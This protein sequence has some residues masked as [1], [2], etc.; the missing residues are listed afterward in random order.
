[1][2]SSCALAF[3]QAALGLS[4]AD[5]LYSRRSMAEPRFD[6]HPAV[7]ELMR[8]P[9]YPLPRT[10]H[11][12]SSSSTSPASFS[13]SS[14]SLSSSS[15]P[16]FSSGAAQELAWAALAARLEAGGRH[17]VLRHA[18]GL[19]ELGARVHDRQVGPG[20]LAGWGVAKPGVLTAWGL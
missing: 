18:I 4:R 9:G 11:P 5:S 1:M 7:V 17:P 19:F 14:S 20:V 2:V 12:S 10:E 16:S 13:S 15:L 6:R 3:S 8:A